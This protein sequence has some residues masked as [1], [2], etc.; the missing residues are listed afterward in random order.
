[1]TMNGSQQV[2]TDVTATMIAALAQLLNRDAATIDANSRLFEDLGID[3]TGVL[4]LLMQL[5]AELDVEFDA[6]TLEP[7][8]FETVGA[9]AAYVAKEAAA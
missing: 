2:G 8:D 3:S 5:E 7:N 1:M 6:E 9:L 4:E